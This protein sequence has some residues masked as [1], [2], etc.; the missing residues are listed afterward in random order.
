MTDFTWDDEAQG[1]FTDLMR[2]GPPS[3]LVESASRAVRRC[4]ERQA[5]DRQ[6]GT[7]QV[8]DVAAGCLRV[9]PPAFKP[10]VVANL[11]QRGIY[12]EL[13]GHDQLLSTELR[14]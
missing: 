6:S 7:V 5:Q 11:A 9:A 2:S 14:A 4:A 1:L 10:N 3:S 8:R 12:I 13:S